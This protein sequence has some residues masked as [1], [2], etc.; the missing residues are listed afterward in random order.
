MLVVYLLSSWPTSPEG[1]RQR[2]S[3]NWRLGLT[4]FSVVQEGVQTQSPVFEDLV[5][6]AASVWTSA[7]RLFSTVRASIR[8]T[9]REK[10]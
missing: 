3:L 4:L 8:T 1:S 7:R 6:C 10:T 2:D 9:L 5:P